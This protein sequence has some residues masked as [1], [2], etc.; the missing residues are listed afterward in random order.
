MAIAVPDFRNISMTN[1]GCAPLLLQ[2]DAGFSV[3][4]VYMPTSVC[5]LL[6]VSLGGRYQIVFVRTLY[7]Q[8]SVNRV[9]DVM[10]ALNPD[11]GD[12][13]IHDLPQ[14]T[15]PLRSEPPIFECAKHVLAA[16]TGR[17]P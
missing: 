8:M 17:R 7:L 12:A 11:A 6:P 3:L 14:E 4:F 10:Q 15:A 2:I 9:H 16:R 13:T 5:G 1:R